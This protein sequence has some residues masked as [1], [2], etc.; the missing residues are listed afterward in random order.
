MATSFIMGLSAGHRRR[1]DRRNR[2][3]VLAVALNAGLI[4]AFVWAVPWTWLLHCTPAILGLIGDA[5]VITGR[6]VPSNPTVE[7]LES[8]QHSEASNGTNRPQLYMRTL[9]VSHITNLFL[10][11]VLIYG[12]FGAPEGVLGA[13]WRAPSQHTWPLQCVPS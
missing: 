9:I 5:A 6:S 4:F 1:E 2:T 13:A 3:D 7:C 12:N 11:W 10:N 8:M